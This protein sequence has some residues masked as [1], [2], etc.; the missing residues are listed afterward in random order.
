MVDE[1]QK[2]PMVVG[3]IRIKEYFDQRGDFKHKGG[4]LSSKKRRR[5]RLIF[6]S[7]SVYLSWPG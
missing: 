7:Q 6:S 4:A 5:T 2:G 1:S 3:S